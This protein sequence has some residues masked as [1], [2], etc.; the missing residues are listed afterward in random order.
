MGPFDMTSWSRPSRRAAEARGRAARSRADHR[1]APA[2]FGSPTGRGRAPR[3]VVLTLV[4]LMAPPGCTPPARWRDS[5]RSDAAGFAATPAASTRECAEEP[6]Q[7]AGHTVYYACDCQAG[8]DPNCVTGR[9]SNAGTTPSAPLRTYFRVRAQFSS[10]Q[11]GDTIAFCQGG[12]FSNGG[13]SWTNTNC[14]AAMPCVIRDYVDPR[15][16]ATSPGRRPILA[17]ATNA[18]GM[19]LSARQH[20]IRILNLKLLAAGPGQAG[21]ALSGPG[22]G[23][24]TDI[25]VCNV[26]V[27]GYTNGI[28]FYQA[29]PRLTVVNSRFVNNAQQGILGGSDDTLIKDNLFH[30]NG[31]NPSPYPVNQGH[32]GIYLSVHSDSDPRFPGGARNITITGNT[33]TNNS[34]VDGVCQA[35]PFTAHGAIDGLLLENNYV[36]G[37]GPSGTDN[38]AANNGGCFGIMLSPGGYR[39]IAYFRNIAIRRNR[40]LYT[41]NQAISLSECSHCVVEANEIVARDGASAIYMPHDYQRTQPRDPDPNASVIVQ[42]NT[43]HYEPGA[44]GTGITIRAEGD[45][46]VVSSNVIYYAGSRSRPS[47][48]FSIDRPDTRLK[49]MDHNLCYSPH[50]SSVAWATGHRNRLEW[51]TSTGWDVSS[52]AIDPVFRSAS[53]PLDFTP[54]LAGDSGCPDTSPLIG[55]ADPAHHSDVAV[56]GPA[57]KPTAVDRGK[58]RDASPDIGAHER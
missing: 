57:W 56:S 48:C 24:S 14:T 8:A 15:W 39:Q 4:A 23:P 45:G 37:R 19:D 52:L 40:L 6:V 55:G 53:A 1:G 58:K 47:H 18:R 44:S 5:K 35:A 22:T 30:N 21:I 46:Y 54:C 10:L 3:L 42:S 33:M 25:T 2:A 20:G 12:S 32:G 26:E 9:D 13:A 27:D 50:A 41:G 11:A 29:S 7:A 49:A 36:D 28:E 17:S 31:W 34:I 38:G 16:T 43:I 51:A